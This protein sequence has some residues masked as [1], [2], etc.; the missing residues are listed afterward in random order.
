MARF[1]RTYGKTIYAK[2]FMWTGFIYYG[3]VSPVAAVGEAIKRTLS[4]IGFG[5]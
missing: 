1:Y 2:N 4:F 3:F 5:Q